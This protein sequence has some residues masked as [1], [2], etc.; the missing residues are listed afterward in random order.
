MVML[1]AKLSHFLVMELQWFHAIFFEV[2]NKVYFNKIGSRR[3]VNKPL[4][5]FTAQKHFIA[6]MPGHLNH[7]LLL[8]K[9][10]DAREAVGIEANDT[11]IYL[12]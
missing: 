12:M 4:E 10:V 5:T 6:I 11:C 3:L 2:K 1:K 9:V 7:T 8:T